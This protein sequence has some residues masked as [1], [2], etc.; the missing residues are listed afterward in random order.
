MGV[1]DFGIRKE[2]NRIV[3]LY[4]LQLYGQRMQQLQEEM[5]GLNYD[6]LSPDRLKEYIERLGI[7]AEEQDKVTNELR[8]MAFPAEHL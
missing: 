4:S 7:V 3:T 8:K 5:D 1:A 6:K 2:L